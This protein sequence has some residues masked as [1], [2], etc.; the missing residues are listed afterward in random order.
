M[1]E[2]L[3]RYALGTMAAREPD[4]I[5]GPI[6]YGIPKYLERWHLWRT[7]ATSGYLHRYLGSDPGRE[8]HDHPWVSAS[9]CLQGALIEDRIDGCGR[10]IVAGQIVVRRARFAHRLRIE[11]DGHE[12]DINHDP[13]TLFLTGP[14]FRDWGFHCPS[15]WK[16]W[17]DY[18]D[19][20]NTGQV[21]VGC[22]E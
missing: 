8:L 5:I 20:Q 15:G 19:A 21:G 1:I 11:Y 4:M 14:K 9:V 10:V 22:G 2:H 3:R 18:V 12:P 13:L 17:Q 16:P 6:E 7:R